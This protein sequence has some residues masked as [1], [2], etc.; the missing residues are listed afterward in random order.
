MLDLHI[1]TEWPKFSEF[2]LIHVAWSLIIIHWIYTKI[3]YPIRFPIVSLNMKCAKMS[4]Q[5]WPYEYIFNVGPTH[6]ETLNVVITT[7]AHVRI[8]II[9]GH[10]LIASQIGKF[11]G[12]TWGPPGSCRPQMGPMLAPW[13]LLSGLVLLGARTS[14]VLSCC[15]IIFMW[16]CI[17]F[18]GRMKSS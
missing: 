1:L 5:Y 17:V 7:P 8:L 6:M 11:M 16:F 9:A 2:Y 14:A 3:L 18:M 15:I 4:C 10:P 13:S 12:P